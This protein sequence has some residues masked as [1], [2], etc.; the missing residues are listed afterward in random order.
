MIADSKLLSPSFSPILLLYTLAGEW[1]PYPLPVPSLG[2][3][4]PICVSSSTTSM[5]Q[6]LGIWNTGGDLP[7][8]T[9][10]ASSASLLQYHTSGLLP[11]QPFLCN[12]RAGNGGSHQCGMCPP[13]P[14]HWAGWWRRG[15]PQAWPAFGKTLQMLYNTAHL[16]WLHSA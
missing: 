11:L 7:Q 12:T 13:P 16:R 1:L 2:N 9:K 5:F 10:H 14:A 3:L 6:Q 8:P 4:L 15:L